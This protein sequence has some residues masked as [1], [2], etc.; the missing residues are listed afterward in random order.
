VKRAKLQYA[1]KSNQSYK[2]HKISKNMINYKGNIIYTQQF[3]ATI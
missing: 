2:L 3:Q 1:I